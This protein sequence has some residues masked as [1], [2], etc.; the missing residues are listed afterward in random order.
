MA[1]GATDA[2][3]AGLAYLAYK[4]GSKR[5][6]GGLPPAKKQKWPQD[7]KP[8]KP[9]LSTEDKASIQDNEARHAAETNKFE[10][11]LSEAKAKAAGDKQAQA[12]IARREAARRKALADWKADIERAKRGEGRGS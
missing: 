10:A 1:L 5:G 11:Q 4:W 8:A 6:S 3:L 9:P 7:G 2:I 12:D